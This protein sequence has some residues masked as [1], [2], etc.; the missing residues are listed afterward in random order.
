M[1]PLEL[2]LELADGAEHV[3]QQ[4]ADRRVVQAIDQGA[5]P[6]VEFPDHQGVEAAA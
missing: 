1:D 3:H 2:P 4:P 6:T 5:A